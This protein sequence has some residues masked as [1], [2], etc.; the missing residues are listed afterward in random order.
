MTDLTFRMME[1]TDLPAM[2]KIENDCQSHPWSLLQFLDGFNSG[3]TGWLACREIDGGELLVG[4]AVVASVL[5][6]STLLNICVRPACQKQGYGR[7]LLEFVLARAAENK[8][9]KMFLE[10]RASNLGAIQLYESVGF[11]R[12]DVRRDYYPAVIG[13][14]DGLVYLLSSFEE[15]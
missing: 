3:H 15:S 9:R 10:V 6:E 14:E 2:V 8:I 7:S 12:I 11:Q 1:K 13:R 4:F 5:D